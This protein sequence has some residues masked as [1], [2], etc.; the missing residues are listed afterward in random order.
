MSP[1]IHERV[2]ADC[3]DALRQDPN[4]IKALN[5]CTGAL[6]SLHRYEESLRGL[7]VPSMIL[8]GLNSFPD[9]TAATILER[10]QNEAAAQSVERVLKK[11]ATEKAQSIPAVSNSSFL[12]DTCSHTLF[13]N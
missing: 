8:V 12:S 9:Y 3:D 4:H 2:V 10:S 1:P 7:I 6:E 11:L 5:R 13:A